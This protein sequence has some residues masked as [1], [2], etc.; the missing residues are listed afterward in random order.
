MLYRV[1]PDGTKLEDFWNVE[2]ELTVENDV[3]DWKTVAE[4]ANMYVSCN[5]MFLM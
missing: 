5:E 2:W 3:A 1:C 4:T